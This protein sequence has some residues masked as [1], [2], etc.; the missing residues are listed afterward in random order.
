MKL[1]CNINQAEA[2]RQGFEPHSTAVIEIDL[3]TLSTE[4][5]DVLASHYHEGIFGTSKNQPFSLNSPSVESVSEKLQ[6]LITARDKKIASEEAELQRKIQHTQTSFADRTT[7]SINQNYF[8]SANT[9][10]EDPQT[11]EGQIGKVRMDAYATASILEPW[12]DGYY[13]H[14]PTAQELLASPEGQGWLAELEA[15]NQQAAEKA[16][17][18]AKES[19]ARKFAKQAVKE[20]REAYRRQA[21]IDHGTAMQI[22]R[23]NRNLTDW[24]EEANEILRNLHISNPDQLAV[25]PQSRINEGQFADVITDEEMA[26]VLRYEEASPGSECRIVDVDSGCDG[27]GDEIP[28]ERWLHVQLTLD[29]ELELTRQFAIA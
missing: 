5:R 9:P 24:P 17:A 22:E 7:R 14:T 16:I 15:L 4:E 29:H 23:M 28:A 1:T 20:A 2:I 27:H 11:G 19:L 12:I 3:A 21:V 18:A 8:A 6:R 26:I 10:D 13:G 25:I